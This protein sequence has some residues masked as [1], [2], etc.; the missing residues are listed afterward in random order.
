MVVCLRGSSGRM[1]GIIASAASGKASP[2]AVRIS[3]KAKFDALDCSSMSSGQ[4]SLKT[5][6]TT[7]RHRLAPWSGIRITVTAYQFTICR[8]PP[9]G[10]NAGWSAA[11]WPMRELSKLVL[12]KSESSFTIFTIAGVASRWRGERQ[13]K[14]RNGWLERG[15]YNLSGGCEG[16]GKI[17]I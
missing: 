17:F 11:Q 15:S 14:R 4:I 9:D 2:V 6:P 8:D 5:G 10:S 3:T 12:T 1:K 16:S 7:V 13:P